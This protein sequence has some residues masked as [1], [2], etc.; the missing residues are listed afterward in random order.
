SSSTITA[1]IVDVTFVAVDT[2]CLLRPA[3]ITD[4]FP[5]PQLYRPKPRPIRCASYK[6]VAIKRERH[7]CTTFH[8]IQPLPG[9]HALDYDAIRICRKLPSMERRRACMLV[10]TRKKDEKL[11]IGNEIEIQVLRIGRDNVR[12]GIKAP[13]H[14]SIYRYEIYEAIKQENVTAV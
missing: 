3:T 4:P 2:V 9:F 12:L 11:I 7:A 10:V 13:T 8:F 5:G 6:S 1:R 14:I